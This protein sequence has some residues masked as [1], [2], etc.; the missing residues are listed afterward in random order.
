MPKPKT[1]HGT[2]QEFFDPI[3]AKVGEGEKNDEMIGPTL[4][5]F[6]QEP[7]QYGEINEDE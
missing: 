3:E 7:P 1:L 2:G 5:Y 6:K 4:H